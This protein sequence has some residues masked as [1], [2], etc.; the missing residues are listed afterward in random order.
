[1]NLQG[2]HKVLYVS[3]YGHY[4]LLNKYIICR[5]IA[6]CWETNWSAS[7][8]CSPV[9]TSSPLEFIFWGMLLFKNSVLKEDMKFTPTWENASSSVHSHCYS[10][11]NRDADLIVVP[12]FKLIVHFLTKVPNFTWAFCRGSYSISEGSPLQIFKKDEKSKMAT[13]KNCQ[14]EINQCW[15]NYLN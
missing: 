6:S 10:R 1:M 4:S 15:P 7:L 5:P 8:S 2:G 11:V 13:V 12:Y 14:I 9:L 3:G